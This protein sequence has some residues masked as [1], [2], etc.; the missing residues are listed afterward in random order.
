MQSFCTSN[1][2]TRLIEILTCFMCFFREVTRQVS[3]DVTMRMSPLPRLVL[4]AAVTL[5]T[6][7][8]ANAEINL[9]INT[10]TTVSSSSSSSSLSAT[11]SASSSSLSATLASPSSS[12]HFDTVDKQVTA[13]IETSLLS[14]LGFKKRPNPQGSTHVP[15]SLKELQARQNNIDTTNFAKPGIHARSANTVRSFSHVGECRFLTY[16]FNRDDSHT[17]RDIW[18]GEKLQDVYREKS[19]IF[20]NF[21]FSRLENSYGIIL[22]ISFLKFFLWYFR[23]SFKWSIVLITSWI[24]CV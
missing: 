19:G 1:Y 18:K 20:W 7:A 5:L 22:T 12:D 8:N 6:S 3:D 17:G 24:I 13:G 14:L 21:L 10:N 11:A 9:Y 16:S 15:E 23:F 4:V 2:L